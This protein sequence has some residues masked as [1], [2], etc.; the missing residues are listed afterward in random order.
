MQRHEAAFCFVMVEP[1]LDLHLLEHSHGV[2]GVSGG[3]KGRG[4]TFGP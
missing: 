1:L 3:N 4:E 2:A